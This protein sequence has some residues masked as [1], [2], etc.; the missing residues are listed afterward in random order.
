MIDA[1]TLRKLGLRSGEPVRF[2][3]GE[4]GRWFAG[5]MSGVAIDGSITVFDANGNARSL[6]PER[7]EVRRPGSRGRLSWQTVSDVAITWEQL[8]LW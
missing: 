5:K 4:T 3:K 8:E 1:A 7:V 2:R 6:K